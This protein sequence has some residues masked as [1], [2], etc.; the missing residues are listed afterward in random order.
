MLFLED[1]IAIE[2]NRISAE[3]PPTI[4]YY[5]KVYK[6]LGDEDNHSVGYG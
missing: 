4:T 1:K 2:S 6:Y 3:T 5:I